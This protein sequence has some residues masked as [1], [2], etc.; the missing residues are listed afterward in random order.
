M[1]DE[2]KLSHI[3]HLGDIIFLDGYS[4]KQKKILTKTEVKNFF[5][6][7]SIKDT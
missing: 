1:Y 5:A 2:T 4:K 6:L 7:K 3:H